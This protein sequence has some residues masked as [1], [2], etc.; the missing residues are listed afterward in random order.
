MDAVWNGL[1]ATEGHNG[2]KRERR[3]MELIGM[4]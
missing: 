1:V 4:R 3:E 2:S